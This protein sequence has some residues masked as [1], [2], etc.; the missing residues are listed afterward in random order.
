MGG[1]LPSLAWKTAFTTWRAEGSEKAKLG[2]A[3]LQS[4]QTGWGLGLAAKL[5]L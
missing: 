4:E 5:G 3:R 2:A 1:A